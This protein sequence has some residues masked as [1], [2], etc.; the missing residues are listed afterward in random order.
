MTDIEQRYAQWKARKADAD[1]AVERQYQAWLKKRKR[2]AFT[3]DDPAS[4]PISI[5]RK[6]QDQS[7][8][9]RPAER[10][11]NEH[12]TEIAARKDAAD[13]P[14]LQAG[15]L[16]DGYQFGDLTKGGFATLEDSKEDFWTG[17]LGLGE[18][19]VDTLVYMTPYATQAQFAQNGGYYNLTNAEAFAQQNAS[20]KNLAAD[21]VAEDLYDERKLAK[22]VTATP[23]YLL[24]EDEVEQY[25][26]L[27]EKADSLVQSAG[28]LAGNLALSSMGAPGWLVTG[29][30]SFGS[31]AES[32][33]RE[34]ATYEQAGLSATISAVGE[35][36]TERLSGAVKLP[37]TRTLTEM[38]E[39]L[40]RKVS[41]KCIRTLLRC[42]INIGG[43]GFEEAL[44][45]IVER[46]GRWLTYQNDQSLQELFTSDEAKEQA[47][48]AFLGGVFLGG[49]GTGIQAAV[50]SRPDSIN[51]SAIQNPLQFNGAQGKTGEAAKIQAAAESRLSAL[52]ETSQIPVLAEA[53]TKKAMG[54][55]LTISQHLMIAASTF[56]QQ[57][58]D[59][60]D[61]LNVK[62]GQRNSA[63]M[64]GV[65]F[66]NNENAALIT[67]TPLVVA[68]QTD[69]ARAETLFEKALTQRGITQRDAEH[70]ATA[71]VDAAYTRATQRQVDFLHYMRT[72]SPFAAQYNAA[73]EAVFPG[74]TG[75]VT[76]APAVGTDAYSGPTLSV[77]PVKRTVEDA[78]PYTATAPA[79]N[80]SNQTLAQNAG[81]SYDILV[82]T[83]NAGAA[84]IQQRPQQKM[85][86]FGVFNTTADP[87]RE[88]TGAGRNSHPKETENI[89]KALEEAGV[90]LEYRDNAMCYQ[91]SITAGLAG[92]FVIDQEAS[93]S[94]WL[95]EY[96]HFLD[97]KD[98]GYLGFRVF[99]DTEKC[100]QREAHAYDME[101]ELAKQAN[102]PDIVVRLEELKRKELSRYETNATGN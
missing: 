92:R 29:A 85:L 18:R 32:A 95:H 80:A 82:G 58:A 69:P 8:S 63:W 93:Y 9:L 56:G 91:P 75:T 72:E 98:D 100:K 19:F 34:N 83:A 43:E 4:R 3:D 81:I 42:G 46:F 101:I 36:L 30:T 79:P 99:M 96:T 10:K 71:L 59:E 97:D 14:W 84:N 53:L 2:T 25:S 65:L 1:E 17:L 6:D 15:T 20:A 5:F 55:Q 62:S 35:V 24:S 41:N 22:A 28:A 26:F 70:A 78:G 61:M 86:S 76:T 48:D 54:E 21:F 66:G 40:L 23:N 68:I 89:L 74:S 44:S 49:A 52:G 33:L 102:R 77:S 88:V 94:A 38:T 11:Q 7:F 47:W 16:A 57:V 39:G 87:M 67:K 64:R 27:G 45:N 13:A 37:G 60:M 51:A 73:M 31:E 12:R 50:N 90:Q